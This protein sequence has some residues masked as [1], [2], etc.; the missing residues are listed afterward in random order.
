MGALESA[1]VDPSE[2]VSR[3]R[4]DSDSRASWHARPRLRD[5]LVSLAGARR[6]TLVRTPVRSA[7]E[8]DRS[9]LH[10][11]VS[12]RASRNRNRA[13]RWPARPLPRARIACPVRAS[14]ITTCS[15]SDPASRLPSRARVADPRL[16]PSPR[17]PIVSAHSTPHF[18]AILDR[19]PT[20]W[21]PSRRG[22][23]MMSSPTTVRKTTRSS[24]SC[25]SPAP[26]RA[27]S[28]ARAAR[29]STSS[30]SRPARA[31]SSAAPTKPSPEPPTVSSPSAAPRRRSSAPCTS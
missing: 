12:T 5:N 25:S 14:P 28:S 15:T 24:S 9:R 3:R 8:D 4:P 30:R 17:F 6:H 29:P 31:S 22:A 1:N 11:E 16:P 21:T 26:P 19:A 2:N 7:R 23:R 20:A 18:R 10:T 13:E 27:P